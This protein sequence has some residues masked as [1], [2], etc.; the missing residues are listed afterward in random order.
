MSVEYK[1][2]SEF[3]VDFLFKLISIGKSDDIVNNIKNLPEEIQIKYA[4]KLYCGGDPVWDLIKIILP[5]DHIIP[6]IKTMTL[7][8]A[9]G[10][11]GWHAG[12]VSPVCYLYEVLKLEFEEERELLE[13]IWT[14]SNN[15]YIPYAYINRSTEEIK[16]FE[17]LHQQIDKKKSRDLFSR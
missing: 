15:E 11:E 6:L 9:F 14:H 17:D 7:L 13:W 4:P 2:T 1:L 12:S 10:V 16:N 8:E 5:Q 3:P